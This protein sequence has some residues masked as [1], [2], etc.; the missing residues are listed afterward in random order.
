MNVSEEKRW[1]YSLMYTYTIYCDLINGLIKTQRQ[2]IELLES[3]A[4]ELY[5]SVGWVGSLPK[6]AVLFMFHFPG[7][8]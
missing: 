6:P 4:K 5:R 1:P 2:E 8:F 3:P 7:P